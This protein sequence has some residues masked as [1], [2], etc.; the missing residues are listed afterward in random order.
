[1]DKP[2]PPKMNIRKGNVFLC[3]SK[4][5]FGGAVLASCSLIFCM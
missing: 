1:M 5:I 2:N 4:H 3:V